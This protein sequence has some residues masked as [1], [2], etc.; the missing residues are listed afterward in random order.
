MVVAVKQPQYEYIVAI[1]VIGAL[2]FGYGTGTN[3]VA[4][5]F[6]TFVGSGAL[7]NRQACAMA[8]CF[9]FFGALVLGRVSV[10]TIAGGIADAKVF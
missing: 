9:K 5:A 7:T 4:N 8:A 1:G 10:S 6:G 3:D 2:G